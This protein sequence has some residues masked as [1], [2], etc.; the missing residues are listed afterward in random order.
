M[1]RL[2]VFHSDKCPDCY[3][4]LPYLKE[5]YPDAEFYNITDSMANL[6]RFLHYRDHHP[7]FDEVRLQGWVGIPSVVINGGQAVFTELD[8]AECAAIETWMKQG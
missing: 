2:Q 7:E 5:T 3:S 4:I 8:A 1:P 6:K